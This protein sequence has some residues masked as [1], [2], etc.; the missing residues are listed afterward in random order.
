[1]EFLLVLGV[2]VLAIG[3]FAGTLL[4]LP[5]LWRGVRV[6]WG[7]FPPEA[8][9][10]GMAGGALAIVCIVLVAGLSIAAPWGRYSVLYVMAFFGGAAML[11][12]LIG[13]VGDARRVRRRRPGRPR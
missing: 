4:V 6:Q 5:A 13:V 2:V 9:R 1:M 7:R 11:L 10:R 8:R 3:V 12:G